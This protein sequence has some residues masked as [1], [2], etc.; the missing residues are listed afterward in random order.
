MTRAVFISQIIAN[1][2]GEFEPKDP[3]FASTTFTDPRAIMI[4]DRQRTPLFTVSKRV[5]RQIR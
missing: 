4:A 5:V 2:E 3:R 1:D